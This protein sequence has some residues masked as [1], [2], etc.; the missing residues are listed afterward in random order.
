MTQEK[1]RQKHGTGDA[2]MESKYCPWCMD[3]NGK[4]DL[5]FSVI[6]DMSSQY[7]HPNMIKYC[8]VCG[9]ELYNER[10]KDMTQSEAIKA[11]CK[12][13]ESLTAALW[14]RT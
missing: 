12:A 10:K 4:T 11:A 6:D 13:M 8:V 5:D 2:V 9:R 1:K 7:M 3:K 14:S